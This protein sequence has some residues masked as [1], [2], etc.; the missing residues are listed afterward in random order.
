MQLWH[1]Y[2][3]KLN[4]KPEGLSSNFFFLSESLSKIECFAIFYAKI[5]SLGSVILIFKHKGPKFFV[6][7]MFKRCQEDV[8]QISWCFTV[9]MLTK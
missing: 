1:H 3:Q 8:V 6:E 5:V 9:E 7:T 4:L 2:G